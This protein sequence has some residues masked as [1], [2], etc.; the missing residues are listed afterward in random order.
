M[1]LV[2]RAEEFAKKAHSKQQRKNGEPFINHPQR[3]VE[4]IE[5]TP[6]IYNLVEDMDMLY[7]C[8]W[9]HDVVEDTDITIEDIQQEF[10]KDISDTIEILTRPEGMSYDEYGMRIQHSMNPYAMAV[11]YVDLFDN[12]SHI[13]D[14]AFK[15][16]KEEIL[17]KRWAK[18]FDHLRER[19]TWI[20]REKS[21]LEGNFVM[22][23]HKMKSIGYSKE[24]IQTILDVEYGE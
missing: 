24:E 11:K 13:G 10:G 7:A 9:L 23:L 17:E 2:N 6:R 16:E 4:A 19:I 20:L 5:M 12:L 8:A 3:V 18:L 22:L 14:G 15:K 1:D 21:D